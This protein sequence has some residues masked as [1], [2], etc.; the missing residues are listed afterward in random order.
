MG[1]NCSHPM[2]PRKG[3]TDAP[4]PAVWRMAGW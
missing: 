2:R 1:L 3:A 4:A